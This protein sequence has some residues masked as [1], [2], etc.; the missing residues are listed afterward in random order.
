M[1]RCTIGVARQGFAAVF[2]C[3]A[4]S[5][6][7][8]AQD[9]PVAAA[10]STVSG[11]PVPNE[12]AMPPPISVAPAP[13]APAAPPAPQLTEAQLDQL[14]APIAL[15]PDPLVAQILMASTYPLEV[16]EAA[17]W[18]DAPANQALTGA[19]LTAA[20]QTQDWDPSVK[21]LAAFPRVLDTMSNQLQWTEDLG[22][23]FLAQQGDIMAAVQSLRHQAM[24]AGNLKQTPQC[25]C[26]I[27]VSGATISILPAEPQVMCVQVYSPVVY[28]Q[29]S[30]PAYPPDYFPAPVGFAYA[31]GFWIGFQPPIVLVSFG[32]LWG[33]GPGRLGASRHRR[34]LRPLGTRFRRTHRLFGQC[35]GA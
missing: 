4:V 1:L 3:I 31:P 32:P 26:A 19:V 27:Q 30:Y 16:V 25:R 35:V 2:A 17:R 11:P 23:A 13:N 7:A 33:L 22:N 15:Y 9:Q 6:V 29:W 28:G 8:L 18:V 24:A 14:V 21:A 20:V 34:R 5:S 12:A 10:A